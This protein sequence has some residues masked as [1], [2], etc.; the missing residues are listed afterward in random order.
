MQQ[1][2]NNVDVLFEKFLDTI[3]MSLTELWVA[4]AEQAGPS[5][6]KQVLLANITAILQLGQSIQ[7]QL[8]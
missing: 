3:D 6:K 5:E 1:N 2:S 7:G 4:K 8:A